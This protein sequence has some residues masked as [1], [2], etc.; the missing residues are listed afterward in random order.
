ME[1]LG[2][3]EKS[4]TI[5]SIQ[6]QIEF[7]EDEHYVDSVG[8]DAEDHLQNKP[9]DHHQEE[10]AKHFP[11]NKSFEATQLNGFSL[12]YQQ[13]RK[14]SISKDL[15]DNYIMPKEEPIHLQNMSNRL[16]ENLSEGLGQPI[17]KDHQ[18]MPELLD[19]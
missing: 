11:D 10:N 2:R 12:N 14:I 9:F 16:H 15:F 7:G 6:Y 17:K 3:E 1:I 4:D 19:H 5:H 8:D 13:K 18:N